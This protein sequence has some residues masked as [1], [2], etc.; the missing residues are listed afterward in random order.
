MIH[1]CA[2]IT[3]RRAS[4][5]VTQN[6]IELV[7]ASLT[8][9]EVSP[10]LDFYFGSDENDILNLEL[11]SLAGSKQK[12]QIFSYHKHHIKEIKVYKNTSKSSA[13][14]MISLDSSNLIAIWNIKKSILGPYY[15]LRFHKRIRKIVKNSQI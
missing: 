2:L 8:C 6:K 3:I 15:I 5:F 14:Y 7:C 4:D 12:N 1:K 9:V 11:K 13:V 10:V